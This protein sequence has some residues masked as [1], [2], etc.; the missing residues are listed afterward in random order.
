MNHLLA[1]LTYTPATWIRDLWVGVLQPNMS[2]YLQFLLLG[3]RRLIVFLIMII[4][5]WTCVGRLQGADETADQGNHATR[6]NVLL[7]VIDDLNTALGCYGDT[8]AST[9]HI[10]RLAARSIRFERAYC[11]GPACN[12]SRASIFSGMRPHRIGV[13]DNETPWPSRLQ[14][15]AY[16]PEFFQQRGYYTATFGK[17]LDH[18]RVPKQPYW[19]MEFREWGK[20][21]PEEQILERGNLFPGSTGSMYWAKLKDQDEVTP[22][23]EVARRAAQLLADRQGKNKP[24]LGAVG[25]RRPH[26]PFAA[27][28]RYFD[29]YSPE[30]L[31]L[32]FTPEGY[33]KT[34]PPGSILR[35]PFGGGLDDSLRA[36]AAYYA[37]VS[38]VDAQ[39]GVLLEALDRSALWDDTIVI[40]LS[41]H[42][43]HTGHQGR[44]HKGWLFEQTTRVPLI[45]AGPN[46]KA[47]VCRQ[48]VE[49]IDLFPTLVDLCGMQPSAVL[50]GKSLTP[51]LKD[52]DHR[53][54]NLAL[55]SVG[56]LDEN[57]RRTYVGHSLRTQDY[58]YTEWDAAAQ[59]IEFYAFANDPQGENNLARDPA[60]ADTIAS[61]RLRLSEISGIPDPRGNAAD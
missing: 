25:F 40:F 50:E 41:D 22:D 42:G 30:N 21:P 59:G 20:N 46:V 4:T 33:E 23:G 5:L 52:P 54:D 9:P 49:L 10:D 11:Q 47:G 13:L 16:L 53:W 24:F 14:D 37:C 51:L 1:E 57:E 28:K 60:Q 32:T 58:R 3:R 26:T 2:I 43:Y 18:K 12:A 45:I 17:V 8:V 35:K 6:L 27:P 55:T 38:Y 29:L 36:L 15:S 19:D 7:I 44:W 39:V 34:L 61:L 48:I 31:T 56:Y